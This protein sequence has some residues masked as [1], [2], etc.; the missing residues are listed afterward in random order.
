MQH[1]Q[2]SG[3]GQGVSEGTAGWLASLTWSSESRVSSAA[4]LAL[5]KKECGKKICK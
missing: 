3:K 5:G 2:T 1:V 4:I